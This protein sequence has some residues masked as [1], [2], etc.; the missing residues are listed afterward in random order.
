VSLEFCRKGLG[1]TNEV[2]TIPHMFVI[3]RE[4]KL[5]WHGSLF[6][7]SFDAIITDLNK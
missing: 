6:D 4:G 2:K 5:A 7:P 1:Q 3:D